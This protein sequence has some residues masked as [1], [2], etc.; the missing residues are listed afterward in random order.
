MTVRMRSRRDANERA[1]TIPPP[2]GGEGLGVWGSSLECPLPP[3]LLALHPTRPLRHHPPHRGEGECSTRP[4]SDALCLG[5]K[6]GG[7]EEGGIGAGDDE[8]RDSGEIAAEAPLAFEAG[9][10]RGSR[11]RVAELG[12]DAAGYVDAAAGT[13]RQ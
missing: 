3:L 9:A 2:P 6:G 4:A 7:A 12:H 10:E 11:K 8:R 1:P 13:E 5:E